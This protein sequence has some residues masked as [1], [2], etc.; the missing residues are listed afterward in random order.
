M[1]V[2]CALRC[3]EYIVATLGQGFEFVF[4]FMPHAFASTWNVQTCKKM[5]LGMLMC[6]CKGVTCNVNI[7]VSME[8]CKDVCLFMFLTLFS[9]FCTLG[10]LFISYIPCCTHIQVDQWILGS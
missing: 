1:C 9:Y 2:K 3:G 7:C 5:K 8:V 6:S 10:L 4:M